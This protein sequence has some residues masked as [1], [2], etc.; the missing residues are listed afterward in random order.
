MFFIVTVDMMYRGYC[1][2]QMEN[3]YDY[4]GH[5]DISVR[6]AGKELDK[7]QRNVN[8][9]LQLVGQNTVTY[10]LKLD[11]VPEEKNNG[12]SYLTNYY[13]GVLGILNEE[14]NAL[15]YKL[16]EGRWPETDSEL[17]IPYTLVYNGCSPKD[18]SLKT[19]DVISAEWGRRIDEDGNYT[20]QQI[21]GEESFLSKG[22]REFT[23]CGFID[24]VD[25]TSDKY[26]LYGYTGLA[27][28]ENIE[29]E[30]FV[31]YY[32]LEE[33]ST[34]LLEEISRYF[35]NQ[36]DVLEVSTNYYVESVLMLLENSDYLHAVRYGLYLLEGM[37]I[38]VGICIAGANQYQA[39]EEEKNQIRLFF[40]MGAEKKQLYFL[41]CFNTVCVISA[42]CLTAAALYGIFVKVIRFFALAGVRN[43]QFKG[44]SF[45]INMIFY[46]ITVLMFFLVLCWVTVRTLQKNIPEYNKKEAAKTYKNVFQGFIQNTS[47]L[48]KNNLLQK[49]CRCLIQQL[50]I[51]LLLIF[52]PTAVLVAWSTYKTAAK[53]TKEGATDF[54]L[55]KS[56]YSNELDEKLTDNP[57][58]KRLIKKIGGNRIAYIPGEYLGEEVVEQ[59]KRNYNMD[60]EIVVS[61]DSVYRP[62]NEK[63]EFDCTMVVVFI[64]RKNYERLEELNPGALPTYEEFSSGKNGILHAQI[65]MPDTQETIDVGKRIVDCMDSLTY[66]SFLDENV[67]YTLDII[68]S[69]Q[70]IDADFF[71]GELSVTTYVP[72]EF[73]DEL[74]MDMHVSTTY[75]V[76]GYDGSMDFLGELLKEWAYS[77][78]FHLQ[79]NVSESSSK[80]DALVLQGLSIF[81]IIIVVIIISIVA[82]EVMGKLDYLAEKETYKMYKMLG[83]ERTK[84]GCIYFLEQ[85]YP[86]LDT[87]LAGAC[88][89]CLLYYTVLRQI[90]VYYT[91][92]IA[93]IAVGYLLC[94]AGIVLIL[95]F[96]AR[97]VGRKLFTNNF[98]NDSI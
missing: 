61:D 23:I 34:E 25:Y 19:G 77:D 32:E 29:Q 88:L 60:S 17:V 33:K 45:S 72:L 62:F 5:W 9:N 65:T 24:Y 31:L 89:H 39:M 90:Y 80:K 86:F 47:D 3:A 83:L 85:L 36:E 30:E 18:G 12:M 66:Y 96:H 21:S 15:P 41:Y 93:V 73:F 50:I 97:R 59:V 35:S 48:A 84:A 78:G 95:L 42:G 79:D 27:D 76:D 6:I 69:I 28:A 55:L 74:K 52:T 70:N 4:G 67:N 37:L 13:L 64:D 91:I 68:G 58:V 2:A 49:K 87:V 92:N 53:I 10:S 43:M 81:S 20:Q 1:E 82:L 44:S 14:D 40:S 22:V 26:V 16:K 71:M 54:Y 94:I 56:G 75:W 8:D 63:N 7:Y 11:E 46:C 98:C 51:L 38:L 57:Y